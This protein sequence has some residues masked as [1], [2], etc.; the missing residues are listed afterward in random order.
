MLLPH[1]PSSVRKHLPR[2]FLIYSRLLCWERIAPTIPGSDLESSGAALQQQPSAA[3]L[4][5][6]ADDNEG[7]EKLQSSFETTESTQPELQHFFTFLY[8]LYPLNFTSYVHKPRKY[9]KRTKF[10]RAEDFDLDQSLIRKK[11]EQFRRVHVLHPNFFNTDLED[12]LEDDRW[13]KAD[14]ANVVAECMG[15]CIPVPEVPPAPSP[16]PSSSLPAIPGKNIRTM[17]IP[18]HSLTPDALRTSSRGLS[19]PG[20]S[21]TNGSPLP[22]ASD[23]EGDSAV[24][25]VPMVTGSTSLLHTPS[26][27]AS[28]SPRTGPLTRDQMPKS[29]ALRPATAGE[30]NMAYL[31]REVMLLRSDLNFE[32]Y[33]K[34]QHLSHIGQLQRR[35]I[36]DATVE[37]ETQNMLNTNRTLKAQLDKA[38]ESYVKLKRETIT[39]RSQSKKWEADLTGKV[40][41]L[42]EDEKKWQIDGED[43]RIELARVQKDSDHLKQ[44]FVDVESKELS[45]RQELQ[46]AQIKLEELDTLKARV[47]EL[48]DTIRQHQTHEL[49]YSQSSDEKE[50]LQRELD[51]AN[52]MIQGRDASAERSAK[53]FNH[54]VRE[55]EAQLDA[56]RNPLVDGTSGHLSPQMQTRID[57]AVAGIN[58][59]YYKVK[60]D[61]AEQRHSYVELEMRYKNLQH[62]MDDATQANSMNPVNTFGTNV[63]TSLPSAHGPPSRPITSPSLQDSLDTVY[64][65]TSAP[66]PTTYITRGSSTGSTG[67]R[68]APSPMGSNRNLAGPTALPAIR[69]GSPLLTSINTAN[70]DA[71]SPATA[72]Q[73]PGGLRLPANSSTIT[74]ADTMSINS[75]A[76]F[77]NRS[78]SRWSID[79]WD[80]TTQNSKMSESAKKEKIGAKDQVRVRGRGGAQNIGKKKTEEADPSVSGSVK[81]KGLSALLGR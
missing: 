53:N 12:E 78:A 1:I 68:P 64:A 66:A 50:A 13:L 59:K 11:S 22:S 9:L 26:S 48:E 42:R 54:R 60:K 44:L 6:E 77:D 45:A 47:S 7:W 65:S 36:K 76:A 75:A 17:D 69:A 24:P 14:P 49:E 56:A 57:A 20:T 79:S 19:T 5:L 2:L 55:L 32:R 41:S 25:S 28:A 27:M 71:I 21:S 73:L 37:A 31:Q 81:K 51:T 46:F 52:L 15:L 63:S 39:G 30:A 74:A 33:L 23:G 43:L 3:D 10:P 62:A 35:S 40:R 67:S 38:N 16:P 80:R 34:S 8:G 4:N 70:T 61:L 29:P 72:N 18:S 58:A